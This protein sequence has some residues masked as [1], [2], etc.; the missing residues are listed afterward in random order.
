MCP[1]LRINRWNVAIFTSNPFLFEKE[2]LL[3]AP[4]MPSPSHTLCPAGDHPAMIDVHKHV[5]VL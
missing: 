5:S 4:T 2:E 1:L 3:E